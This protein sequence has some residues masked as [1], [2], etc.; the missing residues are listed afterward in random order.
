MQLILVIF[1]N[2]YTLKSP[3]RN[4]IRER[5]T[6]KKENLENCETKRLS[7]EKSSCKKNVFFMKKINKSNFSYLALDIY[8]NLKT[9]NT[10][11]ECSVDSSSMSLSLNVRVWEKTHLLQMKRWEWKDNVM[12]NRKRTPYTKGEQKKRLNMLRMN[13]YLIFKKLKN[14]N[15]FNKLIIFMEIRFNANFRLIF[16]YEFLVQSTSWLIGSIRSLNGFCRPF[17]RTIGVLEN[18][19][20]KWAVSTID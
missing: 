4:A 10:F 13:I 20:V 19:Y 14:S 3:K 8:A 2:I 6:R 5:W 18:I 1:R 16:Y 12:P 11:I 9:H 7:Y 17:K 15:L